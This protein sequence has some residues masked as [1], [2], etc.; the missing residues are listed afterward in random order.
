M[1]EKPSSAGEN[2]VKIIPKGCSHDCG[3]RGVLKAHVK[4]GRI[5]RFETDNG[6]DPQ[7][8]AYLRAV[9]GDIQQISKLPISSPA[10]ASTSIRTSNGA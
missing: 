4:D 5:I 7:I 8:R 9:K 1:T 2:G 3:G 6:E 10:T